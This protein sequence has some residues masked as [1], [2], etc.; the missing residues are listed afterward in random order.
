MKY[1]M[2]EHGVAISDKKDGEKIFNEINKLLKEN[3]ILIID[4]TG[5]VTM[6][7]FCAKQVFGVLYIDLGSKEFYRRLQLKNV[8]ENLRLVLQLGIQSAL[9]DRS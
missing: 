9:E 5:L 7:T 4:F 6:A 1:N 8:N 3:D 2:S